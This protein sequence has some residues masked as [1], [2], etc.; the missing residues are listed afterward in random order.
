[1]LAR[2]RFPQQE[3]LSILGGKKVMI[4]SPL[5]KE[6]VAEKLQD[7]ILDLLRARFGDV[8][9]DLSKRLRTLR[10]EKR[11]LELN[12]AAALSST[13]DEFRDRLLA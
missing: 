8:P 9:P 6:L 5:I 4:D 7:A 12:R 1:V 3:L 13:L 11:L 10:K 2:L